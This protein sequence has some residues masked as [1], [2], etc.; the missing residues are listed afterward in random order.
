MILC[1][2]NAP[3]CRHGL[4][5]CFATAH[6]TYQVGSDSLKTKGSELPPRNVPPRRLSIRRRVALE[7]MKSIEFENETPLTV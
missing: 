2:S 5:P 1:I 4:G 6:I 7:A 3:R